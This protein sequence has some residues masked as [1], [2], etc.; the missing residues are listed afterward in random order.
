MHTYVIIGAGAA[1]ISAAQTIRGRNKSGQITII[2]A[3]PE[4]YYSRPGLAYYLTGEIPEKQ[5]FPYKANE[6]ANEQLNFL[7]AEVVSVNPSAR[8]IELADGRRIT[9]DKLLIATGSRA[10]I[11]NIPG[12]SGDGVVKLDSIAD[13]RNIIKRAGKARSAVVVGGGI[14]ALEIVEGLRTHGVK[15]HY[16]LR[17]DRYWSNVLDPVESKIVEK[18][19]Q[20]EGV[21]LHYYAELSEINLKNGRVIGVTIDNGEK[22]LCEMVAI[23]IGVQPNI[24]FL[25]NSGIDLD[26][27][28]LVSDK[29]QTNFP[30]VYAAGDIA[31]VNDPITGKG[32]MDVLWGTARDQGIIAGSN[33]AGVEISYSKS[34]S[35]NVTRLAGLTTTIIGKIGS[36]GETDPD[37]IAISRGDSES[38]RIR[39]DGILA[40]QGF[41]VNRLRLYVSDRWIMGASVMGDQTLSWPLQK[42]IANNIDITNIKTKLTQ[43]DTNLPEIIASFWENRRIQHA[44]P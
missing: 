29:M 34:A 25:K 10:H 11:P 21:K 35:L 16:L 23:A 41:D 43:A 2:H 42:I 9:Y 12:A 5:L 38:W 32:R 14:T 31:Q 7:R 33:M 18:R 20:E 3:E 40:Q 30:E 1:G 27:G 24:T 17:K 26:K 8:Y 4:G 37:M 39:P 19:L 15:T 22:I 13:A 44:A 36:T 6:L 28:V